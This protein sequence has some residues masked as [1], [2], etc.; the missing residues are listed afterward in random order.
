LRV[1]KLV[2]LGLLVVLSA[3]LAAASAGVASAG[4]TGSADFTPGIDVSHWQGQPDWQAA[5][6][7]GV[8]FAF[9]KA[10]EGRSLVD[11]Q[12]ATNLANADAAGIAV[13]AYHFARPDKTA[14][15]AAAEADH[16]LDNANLKPR[17]LL[18]VLDLEN[19][20]GLT[21][22]QL[23][24]WVKDWLA[25]VEERLGVKPIIYTFPFFWRDEL[26]NT[27]WFAD[28]GYRLWIAHWG[29]DQPKLP[30]NGWGGHGWT[31]WQY[32]NC[33]AVAGFKGCVDRNHLRGATVAA[34]R[35]KNNV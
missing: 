14:T 22:R 26:G 11:E 8:A 35:I 16:F 32:D 30:A 29:A 2:G 1:V 31:I 6:A 20:G 12:Y 17:N 18:P 15:D 3:L 24:R 21:A 7:D 13:G 28:R 10:T 5:R 34:L 25:R 9:L 23:R 27:S 4:A 33:G 19:D